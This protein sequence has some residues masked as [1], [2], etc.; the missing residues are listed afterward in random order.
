[1]CKTEFPHSQPRF[2][3]YE[4]RVDFGFQ[5]FEKD[6]DVKQL[7]LPHKKPKKKEL[8]AEQKADNK[9]LASE[10]VVVE[11]RIAGLKRFRILSDR[12]RLP[13]LGL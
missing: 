9:V 7:F 6:Y 4:V 3:D 11:H 13:D 5:G 12:L 2:T 1:M 10:R 8:T